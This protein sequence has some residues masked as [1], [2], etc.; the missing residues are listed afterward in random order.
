MFTSPIQVKFSA[1]QVQQASQLRRWGVLGK[2]YADL[3]IEASTDT[4]EVEIG[5]TLNIR[6]YL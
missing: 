6:R 1:K 4:H 2:P 3:A 5:Q